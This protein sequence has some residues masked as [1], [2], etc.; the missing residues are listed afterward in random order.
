LRAA[1]NGIEADLVVDPDDPVFFDH[2]LDHFP[3]MLI[4]ESARQTA[5][6]AWARQHGVAP[7]S[8][9]TVSCSARFLGFCEL[10]APVTCSAVP[11]GNGAVSFEIRQGGSVVADGEISHEEE[12]K[13]A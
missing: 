2:E 13:P 10:D 4:L 6:V 3:G 1:G 5:H 9:V 12:G 7:Q 11:S 8:V